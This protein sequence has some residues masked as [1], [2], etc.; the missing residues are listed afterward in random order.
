MS[1]ST[2]TTRGLIAAAGAALAI[3]AAPAPAYAEVEAKHCLHPPITVDKVV[4]CGCVAVATVGT[5]VLP[6]SQ[7]AC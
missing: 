2:W 4:Y 1:K 6:G 7:W 5:T 3:G